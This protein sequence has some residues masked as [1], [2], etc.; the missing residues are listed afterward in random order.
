M[1]GVSNIAILN[2][3][4][5]FNNLTVSAAGTVTQAGL[6][7]VSGTLTVNAGAVLASSTFAL[8]VA[9]LGANMAGGITSGAAGAKSI[10]GNISIAATGF[11]SFGAVTWTFNGAWTNSSTSGSW[12]A[13]TGTVT[14]NSAVSRIMTFANLGVAEFNNVQF[15]PT[16]AATFTMATNGLRWAAS[17]TL[18]NNAT[19]AT[20]NLALTGT[21]GEPPGDH[22]A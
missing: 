22:G 2:A 18:N 19:L 9:A 4:N 16:A 5:N 6:V 17:L 21:G 8:T 13:G 20:S 12:S 7:D 14:F 10:S 3:A 1:S 15:S 11:F